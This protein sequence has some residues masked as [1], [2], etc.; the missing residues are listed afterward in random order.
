MTLLF[1]G[2]KEK[3]EKK[4]KKQ[5]GMGW[6]A[7]DADER[8][9][10]E[11]LRRTELDDGRVELYDT[12]KT[13]EGVETY[14]EDTGELEG[15]IVLEDGKRTGLL[16]LVKI[17][18]NVDVSQ[19]HDVNIESV[20]FEGKLNVENP[21]EK[22][23]L[24][25]I[26]LS[27]RN[28]EGTDLD[29]EEIKIRELGT[30]EDSN[31]DSREFE[32]SGEAK[33][34]L[35]VKEYINSLPN[36]DSVLNRSDIERDLRRIEEE[37]IE[38]VEEEYISDTGVN[39]ESFAIPIEKENTIYFSIAIKNLFSSPIKNIQLTKEL[40]TDFMSPDIIDTS[41]GY[42]DIQE[43]E[44]VWKIEEE[45]QSDSVI[46]LKFSADV[47]AE[48]IDKISTGPISINYEGT[49]SFAKGLSIGGFDAY[50]RN[51]FYIDAIERDKEPDVWDCSLVFQ[52]TSEFILQL[53]NADVYAAEDYREHMDDEEEEEVLVE[54]GV[55]KFV[56]VDPNDVPPLPEGARWFSKSW[57]Y[58]SP[59][60]PRFRKLLE[61]RVMPDF[62]T[63]VNGALSISDVELYVASITGDV[64]FSRKEEIEER[65]LETITVP[66]FKETDVYA[67]LMIE[68]NGSAPL[69]ELKII[70]RGFDDEFKPPEAEEITMIWDDSEIDIEPEAINIGYESLELFFEDLQDAPTGMFDEGS[71]IEVTYPIHCMEPAKEAIFESEVIYTANTLPVSQEIEFV[72]EVPDIEAVHKRRKF[73]VGKEV[74]PIGDL[75]D[76]EIILSIENIGDM[77]LDNLVLMDK[78][79]EKFE[80][81]DY[82]MEPDEVTDEVGEDTLKW[83]I[84][85]LEPA[86]KLEI[87]YEITGSGEYHPSD[88]QLAL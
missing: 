26:D 88:A 48:S 41:A 38:E 60:I 71:V 76:Y 80:Y 74:M 15:R 30:D 10:A 51:R 81:G 62:Q 17:I 45:I 61:F 58:E 34:L 63:T 66:T 84:D 78:V 47:Y 33:N 37:K 75:G 49:S 8:L 2:G 83:T 20:D 13:V 21:S 9:E 19:D 23:R 39:L 50:T 46:I 32:L 77:A 28:I 4:Q 24:W 43:G 1:G 67:S 16:A 31:V 44:I 40:P 64:V 22:D 25:D 85:T 52:N 86:E 11:G 56:D 87:T 27:L 29:E 36:A 14:D 68:N 79:P 57:E 12:D 70:H 7:E 72:P 5:K 59:N 53:L 42:A 18:E 69:N 55:E 3:K 35:L 82:S 6:G 65:E 73:R 54:E